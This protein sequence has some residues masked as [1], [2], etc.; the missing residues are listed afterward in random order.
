VGRAP[1]PAAALVHLEVGAAEVVAA[2]E[3]LDRR[4]AA[5]GGGFPPGVDDV[6]AHPRVLDAQLAACA[7]AVDRPVL[8]I[9]ERKKQGKNVLP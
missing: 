6:P 8:V 3:N 9:L 4:D 7:V 1:A 5:F 2:V